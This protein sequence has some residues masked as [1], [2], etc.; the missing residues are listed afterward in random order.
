M[1]NAAPSKRYDAVVIGGGPAGSATALMLA[2]AGWKVAVVEKSRYPR[3]KVCG[4][5]ISASTFALLAE[6]GLLEEVRGLAGPEVR[7][8]AIF[9]GDTVSVAPMPAVGGS[10]G[11]WGQALGREHLDLLLLEAATR[12]GADLWQPYRVTSV[13]PLRHGWRCEIGHDRKR[14]ALLADTIVAANGSWEKSPWL[15]DCD[16]PHRESD[17]IAFKAHFDGADLAPDL[18][19][20]LVFPGGYGGMVRSDQGRVSLSCCITRKTLNRCRKDEERAGDAVLRHIARSCQGVADGLAHA[21]IRESWHAAGP[22]RPGIRAAFADGMFRAGNAAGEAHPIIAEGITMA[23]QSA[24]FL[25]HAL[26]SA[27]ELAGKSLGSRRDRPRL[28]GKLARAFR[29]P[30]PRGS[31]LRPHADASAE[32][33]PCHHSA[34][35]LSG[36][37]HLLRGLERQDQAGSDRGPASRLGVQAAKLVAMEP[38]DGGERDSKHNGVDHVLMQNEK[39][40]HRRPDADG[41][42][43]HGAEAGRHRP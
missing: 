36:G 20:L 21:E 5:F 25:C 2:R 9:A 15:P 26:I 10:F 7:R 32:R 30:H 11:K 24:W 31:G 12:A 13:E 35:A 28:F 34:E 16:A 39:L 29:R 14:A 23:I 4:E 3:P 6:L 19:P 40:R 27:Q 33:S 8:V 43:H 41:Q 1:L 37:P 38:G 42:E 22:I 17:L 18:M